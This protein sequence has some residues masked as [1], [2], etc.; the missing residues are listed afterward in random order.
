MAVNNNIRFVSGEEQ[1]IDEVF[2]FLI[3]HH[4]ELLV[5]YPQLN[6]EYEIG[7]D[8]LVI[9]KDDFGRRD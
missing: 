2:D 7:Y 5:T 3:I 6:N 8:D 1:T 4:P 9:R